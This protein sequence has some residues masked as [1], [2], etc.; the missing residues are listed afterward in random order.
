[1]LVTTTNTIENKEIGAYLGIVT[2][3]V[4]IGAN[5]FKDIFASI[6]DVI[7]GRS[8]SYE[9][10]LIEARDKALKEMMQEAQKL[11]AN[12]IIGVDLDYESLGRNGSM[13]MVSACGTA[14]IL[15]GWF[16]CWL[17]YFS[18]FRKNED[19]QRVFFDDVGNIEKH[20]S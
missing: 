13:L 20:I 5:I 2:G 7:G 8:G 17:E 15:K 19:K 6:R 1:M 12:A 18:L 10:V 11:G 16:C 3:E 14:V 9:G 4:I